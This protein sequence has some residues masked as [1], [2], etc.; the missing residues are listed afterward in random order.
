MNIDA[1]LALARGNVYL[2]AVH[3]NQGDHSYLDAFRGS[4]LSP[5]FSYRVAD[6]DTDVAGTGI[7]LLLLGGGYGQPARARPTATPSRRS[8]CRARS[9]WC[10]ERL[11]RRRDGQ[12]L[13]DVPAPPGSSPRG[14]ARSMVASQACTV[15]AGRP[16]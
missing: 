2:L 5:L 6:N 7:G 14:Y 13:H 10:P 16:G 1:P 15:G 8:A 12:A 3:D 11:R 9:S 4:T